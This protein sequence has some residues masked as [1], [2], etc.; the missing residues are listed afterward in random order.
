MKRRGHAPVETRVPHSKIIRISAD[1]RRQWHAMLA[2]IAQSDA[3][4]T[5]AA[6]QRAQSIAAGKASAASPRHVN[7]TGRRKRGAVVKP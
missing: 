5:E 7:A 3:A 1:A 6:R 2:S 4:R